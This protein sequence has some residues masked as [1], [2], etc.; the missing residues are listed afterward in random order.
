MM[1]GIGRVDSVSVLGDDGYLRCGRVV[2]V[3]VASGGLYVD[4]DYRDRRREFVPFGRV[5]RPI[6]PLPVDQGAEQQHAVAVAGTT[7]VYVRVREPGFGPW[8]WLPAA[9]TR[10]GGGRHDPDYAAAVVQWRTPGTD[11]VYTQIVPLERLDKAAP[12]ERS[13]PD[14]PGM[15]AT[16][17][18]PL[19]AG[20]PVLSPA[21]AAVLVPMTNDHFS[22]RRWMC[23]GELRDGRFSVV[24]RAGD[25]TGD[26]ANARF[27]AAVHELKSCLTSCWRYLAQTAADNDR[28]PEL[29][30]EILT[31]VFSQLDTVEQMAL[32]PVSALWNAIICQPVVARTLVITGWRDTYSRFLLSAVIYNCLRGHTRHFIVADGEEEAFSM[33]DILAVLGMIG[34]VAQQQPGIRL[35]CL[36]I[37]AVKLRLML[38][39][40]PENSPARRP[41]VDIMG[42]QY[43]RLADLVEVSGRLPCAALRLLHCTVRLGCCLHDP[44]TR[45]MALVAHLPAYTVDAALR[46]L[47]AGFGAALWQAVEAPLPVLLPA[48]LQTFPLKLAAAH[49]LPGFA[50]SQNECESVV[51][52][53][54]CAVHSADPRPASQYYRKRW[55]Q[56]DLKHLS[57]APLSRLAQ[58][59][60]LNLAAGFIT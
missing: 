16:D 60:L 41:L 51:C 31:E 55:C 5:F 59:F 12:T 42:D 22:G 48:D 18:V 8:I 53:V 56:E 4:L 7:P 54:L 13:K 29:L 44:R 40:A 36:Y 37:G 35:Q 27:L 6:L 24:V 57:L 15:L 38:D 47:D 46:P 19:E 52:K 11:V 17:S 30:T 50:W 23:V 49:C 1:P 26:D 21:A 32:R 10:L 33:E 34:H 28:M 20:L 25:W 43:G 58:H 39:D 45:D 9:M 2:D 14:E 3:D